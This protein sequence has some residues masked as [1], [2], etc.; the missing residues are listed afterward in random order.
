MT[1]TSVSFHPL[2]TSASDPLLPLAIHVRFVFGGV[3]VVGYRADKSSELPSVFGERRR[4]SWKWRTAVS[5]AVAVLI[6][7]IVIYGQGWAQRETSAAFEAKFGTVPQ[8]S[9]DPQIYRG[10]ACGSFKF[11]SQKPSRFVFVSHYSSGRDPEGLWLQPDATYSSL[12]QKL[13]KKA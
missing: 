8:L 3:L 13:C 7:G 5:L 10:E 1:S 6:I 2:G 4:G 11:P 9:F 12:A